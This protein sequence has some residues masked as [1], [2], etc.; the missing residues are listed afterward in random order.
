MT[1]RGLETIARDAM[2]SGDRGLERLVER[3][4]A[5]HSDAWRACMQL[6]GCHDTVRFGTV[7]PVEWAETEVE[8]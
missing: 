2:T 5:G 8:L 7:D 1:H 4:L 6:V 3:A